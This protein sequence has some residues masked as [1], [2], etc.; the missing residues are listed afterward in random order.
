MGASFVARSFSGDREQLVTL[1]KA[2]IAHKGCALLDVI[3]PCVTFNDHE[4]STKSYS[5]TR[6]HKHQAIAT[7]FIP[8]FGEITTKYSEGESVSVRLHDGSSVVFSKPDVS[9]NPTQR[10]SALRYLE[11]HRDLGEIPTGLLY[12]DE[13]WPEMHS[14]AGTA[15]KPLK[16]FTF[17]ELN[18]GRAALE[19]LQRSL[20]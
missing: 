19:E 10:S 15:A 9:Y 1:I 14:I 4:G 2:G 16:E 18:P 7:D 3:S 8:P 17:E 13:D 12:I 20:R 6:Q 5:Y 11:K